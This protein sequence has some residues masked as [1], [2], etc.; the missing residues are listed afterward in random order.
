[1]TATPV[2]DVVAA[3]IVR[4]D[5]ILLAR[6]G[7]DS[8]QAGLW[9][10]PGGKVEPEESQSAALIRELREEL[11]IEARPGRFVATRCFPVSGRIIALHAWQVTDFTG[12]PQRL[13]H[14]E[15]VWITP[16]QASYYELAP[17]DIPLLEAFRRLSAADT[18]C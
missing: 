2:I 5:K 17:A 6:R 12:I 14:S 13:A 18:G 11:N 3:I 1:M 4:E 8:D 16:D 10:F 15:L 7:P 9:E